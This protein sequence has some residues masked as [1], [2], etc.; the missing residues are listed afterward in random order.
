MNDALTQDS[1]LWQADR[2]R[3]R[4]CLAWWRVRRVP[5]DNFYL[6][7]MSTGVSGAALAVGTER[8]I[9][10]WY[11]AMKQTLRLLPLHDPA[12]SLLPGEALYLASGPV[13]LQVEEGDPLFFPHAPAMAGVDKR[14]VR[15]ASAGQGRLF[16][17]DRRLVWQGEGPPRVFPLVQLNSA[18]A[19]MD[20]GLALMVG[21]RLYMAHFLTESLLKWVTYLALVAGE[22]AA[23]T[24][25]RIETSHF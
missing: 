23:R 19:V 11:D 12:L 1:R 22:L 8:S 24:G 9:G 3:C 7:L 20:Q 6:R 25:R 13:R 21:M 2:L 10:E 4:H 18:Y 14:A 16:L 5:G 15:A 17:T